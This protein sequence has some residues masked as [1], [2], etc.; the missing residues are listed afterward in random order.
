MRPEEERKPNPLDGSDYPISEAMEKERR[1]S[2][3]KV[4]HKHVLLRVILF[5]VALGTAITFIT[6]SILGFFS[7]ETGFQI[8]EVTKDDKEP[9]DAGLTL[10]YYFSGSTREVN[11]RSADLKTRYTNIMREAY[12]LSDDVVGYTGITNLAYLNSHP[13]EKVQL[14]GRLYQAL[15][16]SMESGHPGDSPFLG[17][18]YEEWDFLLGLSPTSRQL[19]DPA[20]SPA[21]AEFLQS[22]VAVLSD[23]NS[24]TLTFHENNGVTLHLGATY[25][26]WVRDNEYDGPLLTL[27]NRRDAYRIQWVKDAL[28]AEGLTEGVMQSDDGLVVPLGEL[29]DLGVT[30]HGFAHGSVDNAAELTL[31]A[32]ESFCRVHMSPYGSTDTLA[33]SVK[34]GESLMTRNRIIDPATGYGVSWQAELALLSKELSAPAL[35][36]K[37]NYLAMASGKEA[38]ASR[39]AAEGVQPIYSLASA[40]DTV[41]LPSALQSRVTVLTDLGYKAETY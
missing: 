12:K 35:R 13:D 18:L 19:Y 38:M 25:T 1:R 39:I 28:V 29:G 9:G 16:E 7:Q 3:I 2:E 34:V 14:D 26:D 8:I 20:L 11:A 4:S 22:Y 33:Y 6:L 36:S 31:E 5:F 27:G 40:K 37:A 32:G 17:P 23:P 41:I 24:F 21:H 15:K 10:R 30:F